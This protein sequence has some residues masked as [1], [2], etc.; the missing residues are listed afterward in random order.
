MT[1]KD[2][3]NKIDKEIYDTYHSKK[4]KEALP[5][6]IFLTV[7]TCIFNGSLLFQIIIWGCYYFYCLSNNE[8]LNNNPDILKKREFL[9]EY[10]KQILNDDFKFKR[11]K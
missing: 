5:L 6:V 4:N 11:Y 10:K 2:R 3:I 8:E 1:K 7:I 9:I